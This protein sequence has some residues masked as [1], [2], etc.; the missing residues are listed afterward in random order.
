MRKYPFIQLIV[1]ILTMCLY[2]C[3]EGE[4]Q[5]V[6]E[7]VIE[8]NGPILL[9]RESVLTLDEV[10]QIVPE[11]TR[12]TGTG[13]D[14][15]A[16]G[17]P[18]GSRGVTFAS[19]DGAQRVVVS[20]AQYSSNAVASS[21]YDAAVQASFD[22]PG[23]QGGPISGV[24]DKAFLGTS[25][26]GTETHVGGGALFGNL[27]VTVTLQAFAGDDANKARVVELLRLEGARAQQVL[28]GA[29]G[30]LPRQSVLSLSDVRIIVPEVTRETGSGADP[31]APGA[32]I[33]SRGV[34]FSSEFGAVQHVVISVARYS[35]R[36]EA[37]QA[38]ETAVQ[39][40]IDA[41]GGQGERIQGVGEQAFLGNSAQGVEEHVGGGA[42]FGDQIV[43]VTLQ[44]FPATEQNKARVVDLMLREGAQAQQ[45]Q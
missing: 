26:I 33:A 29:S 7:P 37:L 27:I 23:G 2:G 14:E 11:V 41:P 8:P 36:A 15:T 5:V 12:E 19:A 30:L 20:V 32:P 35:S 22:A 1:V 31:T 44:N 9:A 38:Y 24:G 4:Q 39:A 3:G 17:S 13:P 45:A 6:N 18:I 40:S 16:P 10:E 43:T 21:E 42:L 28:N 34:T 25:Q